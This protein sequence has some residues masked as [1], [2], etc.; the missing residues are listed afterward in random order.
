MNVNDILLK[1]EEIRVVIDK[2]HDLWSAPIPI[3]PELMDRIM[4]YDLEEYT[5]RKI[6]KRYGSKATKRRGYMTNSLNYECGFSPAKIGPPI[7]F[8]THSD[9]NALYRGECA[10][11][12]NIGD[13]NMAP[14]KLIKFS[15]DGEI[16]GSY[17]ECF[18][19]L[20]H[21]PIGMERGKFLRDW[22]IEYLNSAVRRVLG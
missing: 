13:V 19:Y 14:E 11:T 3:F 7:S 20:P 9:F 12:L 21:N 2:E 16:H 5:F 1:P 8:S 22:T 15:A 4:P 17:I 10:D 6:S 18:I